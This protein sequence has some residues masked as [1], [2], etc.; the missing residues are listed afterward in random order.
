MERYEQFPHGTGYDTMIVAKRETK[1]VERKM[2][3]REQFPHGTGYDTM[4]LV[5]RKIRMLNFR[6][7]YV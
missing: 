7:K 2:E 6:C 3:R 5:K 4:I 1:H